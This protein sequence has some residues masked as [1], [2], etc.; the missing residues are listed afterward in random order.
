MASSTPSNSAKPKRN[1]KPKCEKI[2]TCGPLSL[3]P[4]PHEPWGSG[5]VR[6]T[7][8]YVHS[9]TVENLNTIFKIKNATS[10]IKNI[11]RLG[12]AEKL[13]TSRLKSKFT[14]PY[15]KKSVGEAGVNCLRK[16]SKIHKKYS[17]NFSGDFF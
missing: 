10:P 7:T 11:L 1:R 4:P 17:F 15:K 13:R 6:Y 12:R 3:P 5:G 14:G 16:S 9:N 8:E 2:P